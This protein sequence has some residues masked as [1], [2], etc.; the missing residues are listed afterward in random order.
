MAVVVRAAQ[1]QE[2]ESLGDLTVAAYR[3][4]FTGDM[5][6]PAY[7]QTLRDV[8]GRAGIDTVLVALD[9][10]RLVGGATYVGDP[11]SPSA[12]FPERDD[13]GMRYLAVT[14]AARGR[15][16]GERLVR[17]CIDL[18]HES[19]KARIVLHTAHEMQAAQRLYARLGFTRIPALDWS[20]EPAVCLIAMEYRLR[21]GATAA[22]ASG[23]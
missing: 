2:Y 5:L 6:S 11:D 15:G 21:R 7:A 17:A 18:A 12:E 1:P 20:P 9:D 4:V 23:S 3:T 22:V 19:G 8:E 14:P 13:A 16:V 10:G